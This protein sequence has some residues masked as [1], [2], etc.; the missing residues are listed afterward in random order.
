MYTHMRLRRLHDWWPVQSNQKTIFGANGW[1]CIG[2]YLTVYSAWI[3]GYSVFA[4]ARREGVCVGFMKISLSVFVCYIEIC[5]CVRACARAR[6]SKSVCVWCVCCD[7]ASRVIILFQERTRMHTRAYKTYV[8]SVYD[9]C[10][11]A[12]M[13]MYACVCMYY[14]EIIPVQAQAKTHYY[15]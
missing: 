10:M 9:M 8:G 12:C 2:P 11:H 3:P 13:C 7:M 6:L 5:V 1:K 15:M 14:M 4:V